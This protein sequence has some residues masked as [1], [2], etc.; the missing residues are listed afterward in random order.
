[1]NSVLVFLVILILGGLL[2]LFCIYVTGGATM[3]H[4]ILFGGF[5]V[6]LILTLALNRHSPPLITSNDG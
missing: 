2:G 5:L 1:M 3:L 6:L 4:W